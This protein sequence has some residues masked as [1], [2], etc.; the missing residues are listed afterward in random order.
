MILKT[1]E[2]SI[3]LIIKTDSRVDSRQTLRGERVETSCPYN[4]H[5]IVLSHHN[6]LLLF[7]YQ[8]GGVLLHCSTDFTLTLLHIC[9]LNA[10]LVVKVFQ[11]FL[12]WPNFKVLS[13]LSLT[14]IKNQ[15]NDRSKPIWNP[16][17]RNYLSDVLK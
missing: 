8:F 1:E 12:S 15:C 10:Q 5:R 4:L 11:I 7:R 17:I 14:S 13:Y 16:M 6:L 2:N 3:N 9:Y